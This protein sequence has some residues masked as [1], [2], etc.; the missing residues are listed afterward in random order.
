M[1][2]GPICP[3]MRWIHTHLITAL[4]L[5]VCATGLFATYIVKVI[6]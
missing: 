5:L 4:Y 2:V 1:A 6:T 3:D